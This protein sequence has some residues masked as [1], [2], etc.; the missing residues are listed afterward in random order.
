MI[1]SCCFCCVNVCAPS[2]FGSQSLSSLPLLFGTPC[3]LTTQF[4]RADIHVVFRLA[5]YF[6]LTPL[7]FIYRT[8]ALFISIINC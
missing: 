6:C 3:L 7:L 2:M 5:L 1:S 8:I 4:S